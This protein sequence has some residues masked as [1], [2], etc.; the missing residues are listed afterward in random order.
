MRRRFKCLA[1]SH[2]FSAT[3]G[4]IF[5]SDKLSFVDLFGAIC[6]FLNASKG[7][8]AVQLSRDLNIQ[9]K[10]AFVQMH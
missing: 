7:P 5:A 4:T 10:T 8:P 3:S 6:L 1:C 9:Y 2:Q